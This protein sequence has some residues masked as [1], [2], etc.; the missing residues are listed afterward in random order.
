MLYLMSIIRTV[1][2]SSINNVLKQ[3][4]PEILLLFFPVVYIC[5]VFSLKCLNNISIP[6]K[7]LYPSF[8]HFLLLSVSLVTW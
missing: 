4:F 5:L 6:G 1:R 3:F 2:K 8:A 7:H